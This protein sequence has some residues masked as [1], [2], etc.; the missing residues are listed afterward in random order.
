MGCAQRAGH[1]P[2]KRIE[3]PSS[4]TSDF[5]EPMLT[6]NRSSR[7][8]HRQRKCLQA[9]L[10]PQRRDGLAG[11]R[12]LEL[13]NVVAK[14][15]SERSHRFPVIQP[16]SGHRDYSRS[17]CRQLGLSSAMVPC[18]PFRSTETFASL[19]PDNQLSKTAAQESILA[20]ELARAGQPRGSKPGLRRFLRLSGA[21]RQLCERLL[22]S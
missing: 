7:A 5:L 17:S 9:G 1:A 18:G 22:F 13:R 15:P 4:E 12:G 14:Y 6:S 10:G 2:S 16:N 19:S 21:N 11:Q 3:S 20:S 8:G